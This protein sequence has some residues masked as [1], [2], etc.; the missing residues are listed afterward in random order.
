M[1]G[2]AG[3]FSYQESSPVDQDE[4]LRIRDHMISRGPDGKGIWFS[5]GKQVGLAHLRLAIIDLTKAGHQPMSTVDGRL[6]ITFNG[7][8]YNYRELRIECEQK[9]RV[10]HSRSDTEV[11]LHLYYLLGEAMLPRLRGMFAF[12]IWD[13]QDQ[14]LLLARD[15]F[16]IK[17]LYY[18]NNCKSIR[19]ASQ[20]K[21]LLAGGQVDTSTESAGHVGF[22]LWGHIPEPYTLYKGIRALPAGSSL[23]IDIT[24]H[25][26]LKQFFC[27]ADELAHVEHNSL[28]PKDA[29]ERLRSALLDS[30]RHHLIAD[31]PVSIFLSSGLDSSTL[32]AL[33]KEARVA[34]LHTITL[35]FK[36]FI[37]TKNDETVL[38]NSGAKHYGATH[39][40]HWVSKEDFGAQVEHLLG[41]MDQP[42][43]DGVN[44]YFV[45]KAAKDAGLK[46][47]LSGVGGDELFGGYSTFQDIP[48]MVQ[49][50]KPIAHIPGLGVGFR[51]VSAPLLK[52]FTSPKYA[53]LLEYGGDYTGAYLLRRGFYMPYELTDVLDGDLVRE[54]WR[55]LNTLPRLR[56]SI[57]GVEDAHLKVSAME[58]S[59]YMRNQLLRDTDWASMAHSLE[60]RTPLVDIELFRVVTQLIHAGYT[61]SK[62]DMA[63]SPT[64]P[65]PKD[66]L[67]RRKTGFSI[68]VHQWLTEKLSN[69]AHNK[70]GLR[71]WATLCYSKSSYMPS[72]LEK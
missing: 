30:V 24:G 35:G 31:V 20:V 49:R 11:L 12:A 56:Q 29:Q 18:A 36:E 59:W 13:E 28:T 46:V 14:T 41:A 68:P 50:L 63:A 27:L 57:N 54:G 43:I 52:Y 21:A 23:K 26:E 48:R 7:E 61:P 34:E 55:E 8:I 66:I 44:S 17:P 40:T 1:C 38:A 60:V 32:T 25:K 71:G 4:L 9:G 51:Y 53:G 16:G 58:T 72:K 33:A 19:F 47:A 39:H 3:I 37:G 67:N 2:I 62:R 15:H 5:Q 70:R 69:Q 45:C 6:H 22:F 64:S 42:S 10:F 65:L